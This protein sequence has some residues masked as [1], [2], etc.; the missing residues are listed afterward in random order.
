MQNVYEQVASNKFRSNVVIIGFI[1]FITGAAYLI[2]QALN[3][4]PSI[5]LFAGIFSIISSFASYFAGDKLVLALNNAHPA[6]RQQHFDY[7]TVVENLSLAYQIP[8]P[9]IYIID[10]PALNAFATGRDP[11]HAYVCV[12]SGLIE[13][14]NRTQLEGV[15]AHELSHIKNYDIRLMMV[16]SLLI[17]TLSILTNLAYRTRGLGSRRSRDNESSA[18]GVLALVGLFLLIFSP[19]IA[20]LIQLALSRQREYLADASGVKLTRQPQGLIEALKIISQDP[21]IL[22]S[23]ST[24]TASLYISNPFKNSKIASLFS[25]H[26]P[27]EERIK[28]LEQMY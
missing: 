20:Q 10:S 25:T 16:V 28:R 13:K 24:A 17:G 2:V 12:T 23:A 26:P 18:S 22:H 7:Y 11:E 8:M 1:A 6:N 21:D 3:L 9:Q 19:L 4:D 27:I 14:L 5:L 15:I